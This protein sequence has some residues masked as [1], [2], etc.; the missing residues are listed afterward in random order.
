MSAGD[1]R[2]GRLVERE[3]AAEQRAP[4]K[5][6]RQRVGEAA[7]LRGRLLGGRDDEQ[8]VRQAALRGRA[9]RTSRRLGHRGGVRVDADDERPGLGASPVEDRPT[10][11]G[12]EVDDDPVG[13][14]DPLVELADVHLGDPS[15]GH[16][17]HRRN[18]HCLG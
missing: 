3:R 17:A 9:R 5:L 8:G 4:G 2:G 14:G 12:T 16:D 11:A 18:L 1:P 7:E 6:D 10:V 15:A 13:A